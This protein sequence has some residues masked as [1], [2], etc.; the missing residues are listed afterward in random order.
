MRGKRLHRLLQVIAL[1]RGP[2]SW[3][4][5]RLAEH[6]HTTRRNIY[7]DLAIL[8]LAGVPFYYD[9]DYGD[10][11]GYRIR[12]SFF[13][14]HVGLTDQ[15]CFDL[16]VLT[17]LAENEGIPLLNDVCHVR[18]K[19]L[20]TL[21]AKQQALITEASALFEMLSGR[22]VE[23]SR[24]R[25]VML[26]LQQALV[27]KRQIGTTYQGPE[28]KRPTKVQLQPL[29]VFLSDHVWYL[30]AHNN[31]EE[32]TELFRLSGFR[33]VDLLDDLMTV[34]SSFS[35][36]DFVGNAW[37]VR[38]GERD[39]HVEVLFHRDAAQLVGERQ[40]H[41]TQ[42]LAKQ[43]DGSL[44]FR[45]TVCGLEEVKYW[46]LSWGPRATVLKPKELAEEVQRQAR[47]TLEQYRK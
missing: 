28:Q 20:G 39:Y 14:P 2:S 5:R 45:A 7:R 46:V 33:N 15:E 23:T 3:N 16:A 24:C 12:D 25:Q 11:G 44:L 17:R 34:S 6:F 13:F 8:E 4:A 21:P 38:K 1:L 10:G 29:R 9:P 30:A 47:L 19:L 18:D 35:L 26:T 32:K 22:L 36:R 27:L 42:E 37:A 31:R 41:H 43:K 40:W